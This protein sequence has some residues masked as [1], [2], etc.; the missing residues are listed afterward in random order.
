M[1][2]YAIIFGNLDYIDHFLKHTNYK[3]LTQG[4]IDNMNTLTSIKEN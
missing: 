2:H 1:L 3:N 4:E